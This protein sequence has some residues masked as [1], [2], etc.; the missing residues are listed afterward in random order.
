MKLER[1]QNI[2]IV[3]F[4]TTQTQSLADLQNGQYWRFFFFLLKIDQSSEKNR[5]NAKEISP[6][7][8]W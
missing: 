3:P 8:Q 1:L 4:N 5:Q 2:P 7:L 6:E